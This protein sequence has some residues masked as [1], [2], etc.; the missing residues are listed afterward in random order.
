MKKQLLVLM[1]AININPNF[2]EAYNNKGNI[3]KDLKYY[4]EAISNY[5]RVIK[6][7]SDFDYILGKFYIPKMHFM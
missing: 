5:E 4:D 1:K 6:L 7:K 2:A 3:L